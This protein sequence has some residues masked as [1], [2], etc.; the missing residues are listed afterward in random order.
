MLLTGLYRKSSAY[1][2]FGMFLA[3]LSTRFHVCNLLDTVFKSKRKYA[4]VP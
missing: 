1:A 3:C 2:V 4:S